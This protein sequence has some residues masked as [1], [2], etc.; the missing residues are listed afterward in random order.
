MALTFQSKPVATLKASMPS[1]NAMVS[2]NGVNPNETSPANAAAQ[3]NKLLTCTG[4]ASIQVVA[5]EN[6]TLTQTK[7]AVDNG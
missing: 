7:E 6:M 1:A 4:K 5:D 2:F 3:I